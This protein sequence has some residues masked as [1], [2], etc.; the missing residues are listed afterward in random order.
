[1]KINLAEINGFGREASFIANVIFTQHRNRSKKLSGL[2]A[3]LKSGH[4]V[5]MPSFS[6]DCLIID[7]HAQKWEILE[8]PIIS[9]VRP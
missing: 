8:S 2:L 9:A 4:S 1:M 7:G 6:M 3:L 5:T